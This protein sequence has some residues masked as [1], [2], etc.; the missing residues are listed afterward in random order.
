MVNGGEEGVFDWYQYHVFGSDL[1]SGAVR[2]AGADGYVERSMART[3]DG[4]CAQDAHAAPTG[5]ADAAS[6]QPRVCARTVHRRGREAR[7]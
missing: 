7:Q 5:W 3:D 6:E 4:A 1:V 2:A